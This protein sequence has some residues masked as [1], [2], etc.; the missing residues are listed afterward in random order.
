MVIVAFAIVAIPT[1]LIGAQE[2]SREVK[3][4]DASGYHIIYRDGKWGYVNNTGQVVI[5][6][7]F[8]WAEDF[9]EDRAAVQ[10]GDGS[11]GKCGYVRP[12]GSWAVELATSAFPSGRFSEGRAWYHQWIGKSLRF[13]CVDAEGRSV[14]SPTYGDCKPFS[15]GLSAVMTGPSALELE[16]FGG[17]IED[18]NSRQRW[19]CV[20]LEGHGVIS[21]EYEFIEP[22]SNGMALAKRTGEDHPAFIDHRGQAVIPLAQFARHS[23]PIVTGHSFH[24]ERALLSLFDGIAKSRRCL[25][26]A[27]GQIVWQSDDIYLSPF[28]CG[29]AH[30]RPRNAEKVGFVNLQGQ[31][32]IPPKFEHAGDFREGL[33]RVLEGGKWQYIDA[34][35]AVICAG[36][37]EQSWNDAEDYYCGL[38]RVHIG[39][40]LH[41][42]S[43][44]KT[45]W[46]GGA[47][48][49][50]DRRGLIVVL[51]RS[52]QDKLVEPWF[53]VESGG[54]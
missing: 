24:E 30:A 21:F 17:S 13:G 50:I 18:L 43:D 34:T 32:V 42:E 29:L 49:Y 37:G 35:G 15:E 51:C 1:V 33:C 47:W 28:S 48:Y 53:G 23:M 54:R 22:F 26:D 9:F 14:L 11:S 31:Y 52:D 45:W 16:A 40:Q 4:R 8:H 5:V 27:S 25:I 46:S 7:R 12:D 19:G 39:G 44:E 20:D 6:P 10:E 3:R 2:D 41:K 36:V 38:A